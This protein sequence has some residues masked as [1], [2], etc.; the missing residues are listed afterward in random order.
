VQDDVSV[1]VALVVLLPAEVVP[2]L[3]EP[4]SGP[5]Q[6]AV[7]RAAGGVPR[8]A[9][10]QGDFQHEVVEPADAPGQGVAEPGEGLGKMPTAATRAA[11]RPAGELRAAQGAVVAALG[12][13]WS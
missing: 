12:E 5:A 8:I 11:P 13:W 1:R 10:A 3:A 9:G 6:E 4:A 7:D 2:Q